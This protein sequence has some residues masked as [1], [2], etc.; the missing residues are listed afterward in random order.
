GDEQVNHFVFIARDITEKIQLERYRE[1]IEKLAIIGDVAAGFAH[2]IRNPLTSIKGSLNLLAKNE[3][4]H[5]RMY[6]QII[7]REL[8]KIEEVING[9]I[10]LA[11]PEA[12]EVA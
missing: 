1:N 6:H 12:G 9:F 10:S 7:E 4:E 8:A 3:A 11:K 5:D 2:E